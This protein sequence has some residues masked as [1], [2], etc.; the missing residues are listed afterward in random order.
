MFEWQV[1]WL[2]EH[3]YRV[4]PLSTLVRQLRAGEDV[5]PRTAVLTFDDGF[6]S[7]YESAL[8]ILARLG[9]PAT[10]FLVAGY[11]GRRNDWPGQPDGVPRYPL[12]NWTHIRDMDGRGFEF[13][14]HTVT[15]PRLDRLMPEQVER[16]VLES[17]AQI[18]DRLGHAI[19]LFAYPYGRWTL[20]VRDVV[21]RAYS[22]AC[23]TF[24]ALVGPGSDPLILSRIEAH[25][26]RSPL[27]LRRLPSRVFPAYLAVR[28]LMRRA[29]S[30]ACRREW[31]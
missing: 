3:D 29:S 16:E 2:A 1:R 5:A 7:V 19:G 18:E 15:H 10:V 11:C 28:R 21:G 30:R 31:T 6:L 26:V 25:Y 20:P 13:G 8:P 23:T 22:G 17:K 9:F 27:T 14:A 24:Q 4:I 12:L